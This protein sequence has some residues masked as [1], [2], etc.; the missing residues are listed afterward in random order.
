[1][2]IELTI[3]EKTDIK[4]EQVI[5]SIVFIIPYR[6]RANDK[7]KFMSHMKD[8]LKEDDT[9]M[10]Y[11]IYFSHQYDKRSFNRGAMKNI[12]FLAIK[13]KYPN[14]YKDITFV[15]NDV[16]TMPKTKDIIDYN[17]V[18]GV[19][20]HYYG[21]QFALGGI[22]SIKGA[23]FEKSKG[24]PNFW[25]WGLEDSVL[26]K[27]CLNYDLHIDRTQFFKI[28]SPIIL[29]LFDGVSRIIN[30]KEPWRAEHDGGI[31][32][33]NTIHQ[34]LFTIDKTSKNNSDNES[35]V[36][37]N[38]IFIINISS[39]MTQHNFQKDN[40]Y[41]YDLRDPTTKIIKPDNNPMDIN[42]LSN[43]WTDIP[44]NNNSKYSK[45][46]NKP[47]PEEANIQQTK[48]NKTTVIKNKS[49]NIKL[50]GIFKKKQI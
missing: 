5:P 32:G 41:L 43:N 11:E 9:A 4:T 35:I 49:V 24:F 39:F 36:I 48:N 25:G 7:T 38:K 31:D 23:D 14:H 29:Q 26:Q 28:G 12:G 2:S 6:N 20:K 22:F 47:I 13:Q 16:D 46:Y 1:M 50:G 33:L 8:V 30:N 10:N 19:V 17:T 40:Y 15:F 27:R 45:Y 3:S 21:F 18:K 34:L 44:D 42:K 37:S